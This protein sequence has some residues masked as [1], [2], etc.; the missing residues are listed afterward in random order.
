MTTNSSATQKLTPKEIVSLMEE[1]AHEIERAA[2]QELATLTASVTEKQR[3]VDH[4][5]IAA[6]Q[7][8]LLSNN[9]TSN[10]NTL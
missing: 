6:I 1:R 8:E 2:E 4:T 5:R 3:H 9:G 7:N 10:E